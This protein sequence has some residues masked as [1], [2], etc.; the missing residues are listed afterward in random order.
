MAVVGQN[1]TLFVIV[2]Y[3]KGGFSVYQEPQTGLPVLYTGKAAKAVTLY[4]RGVHISGDAT[5][6]LPSGS[7]ETPH[8]ITVSGD[9]T[10]GVTVQS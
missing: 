2:A 6:S 1:T 8:K 7:K 5:E 3:D 9:A 10:C 4:A